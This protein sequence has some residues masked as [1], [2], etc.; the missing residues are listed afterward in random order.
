MIRRSRKLVDVP[1]CLA[2]SA[3]LAEKERR[4][5]LRHHTRTPPPKKAYPF[6]V[7]REGEVHSALD[8]LFATKCAYCEFKRA[9]APFDIEH[10]RPKGEVVEPCGTRRP[11]YWWLA[12][13]WTNLLPACQDCNRRRYQETEAGPYLFGKENKFPLRPGTSRAIHPGGEAQEQPLLLDPSVDDPTEH[14][15]FHVGKDKQGQDVSLVSAVVKA[16]GV[17]D[18]RGQATIDTI[19][20]DRPSL[21]QQRMTSIT[22]LR[23]ALRSVEKE[24]ERYLSAD[25]PERREAIKATIRKEM[26]GVAA[27]FLVWDAEYSAACRAEYKAWIAA[28]RARASE[29]RKSGEQKVA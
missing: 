16:D 3:S 23:L 24:W 12:S 6:S 9:G 7:Y 21:V 14:I 28:I 22:H 10:Y 18:E 2:D 4:K 11:G 29:E 17:K 1:A 19:G 27:A 15:C 8:R 20:L 26:Q 13:T 25:I 5:A